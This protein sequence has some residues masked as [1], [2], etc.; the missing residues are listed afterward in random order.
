MTDPTLVGRLD[1]SVGFDW[2]PVSGSESATGS[3]NQSLKDL[4]TSHI[5][6]TETTSEAVNRAIKELRET[7]EMA[8]Q[9]AA[10]T[11]PAPSKMVFSPLWS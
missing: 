9:S 5:A 1:P 8:T 3:V 7:A 11:T 2:I 10:K 4:Q 6:A